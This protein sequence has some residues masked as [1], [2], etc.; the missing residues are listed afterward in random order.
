MSEWGKAVE[1][2]VPLMMILWGVW[3]MIGIAN[4]LRTKNESATDCANL[5]WIAMSPKSPMSGLCH[6][7]EMVFSIGVSSILEGSSTPVEL[8]CVETCKV[9]MPWDAVDSPCGFEHPCMTAFGAVV[10]ACLPWSWEGACQS[11]C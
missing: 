4:Q 3:T 1:V 5:D 2:V 8:V 7:V 10:V 6:G 9:V 11:L